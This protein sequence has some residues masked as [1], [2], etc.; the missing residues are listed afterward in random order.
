MNATVEATSD[1]YISVAAP[2]STSFSGIYNYELAASIDGYFHQV[3]TLQPFL[4]FI[5]SDVG[6]AL[7]VT[8]NV[9]QSAS[10]STNYK[11]WMDITPPYTIFVSNTNDSSI[12]GLERSYCALNQLAQIGKGK[13]GVEVGMTNR[14]LGKKPKEQFYV[15]GLNRSST[16]YGFLAMDGNSTNSGNGV[17]GGGGKVWQGM[18]FTTKAG[19]QFFSFEFFG[20]E[21]SF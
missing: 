20:G 8:N 3:D 18:N 1:V 16:Y 14:G 4:F 12:Q 2:N 6:S 11:E 9:T 5:D 15:T 10:N 19:M 17:I 7:L 13:N 21:C